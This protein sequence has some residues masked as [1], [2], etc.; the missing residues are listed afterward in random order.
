M[1][2]C[3]QAFMC[4]GRKCNFVLW[5]LPAGPDV[6][7]L[8]PVIAALAFDEPITACRAHRPIGAAHR[9]TQMPVWINE[10]PARSNKNVKKQLT[11]V[12]PKPLGRTVDVVI[13]TPVSEYTRTLSFSFLNDNSI[14]PINKLTMTKPRG[15]DPFKKHKR[16]AVFLPHSRTRAKPRHQFS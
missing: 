2:V 15:K 11:R 1:C 13:K 9:Y 8:C 3:V 4:D 12:Y 6:G 10:L 5:T 14:E 7:F 16:N